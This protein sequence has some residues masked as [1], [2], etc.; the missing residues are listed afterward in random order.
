M[1]TFVKDWLFCCLAFMCNI[2]V[3]VL[4]D[5]L[6][7]KSACYPLRCFFLQIFLLCFCHNFKLRR[8][9]GRFEFTIGSSRGLRIYADR[10]R[11]NMISAIS[12]LLPAKR[13][14]NYNPLTTTLGIPIIWLVF[15]LL[16]V[17]V[18]TPMRK[19]RPLNE[20]KK[21]HRCWAKQIK[22]Q[23]M[24]RRYARAHNRIH[25]N[26]ATLQNVSLCPKI[27]TCWYSVRKY[28]LS[29]TLFTYRHARLAFPILFLFLL[30]CPFFVGCRLLYKVDICRRSK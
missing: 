3:T 18:Y 30:Q 15:T 17:R 25:R 11:A 7:V 24:H 8:I 5:T 29:L 28:S 20:S 6:L 10:E 22:I 23:S 9:R 27:K 21:L 16:L 19:K 14:I 4:C 12:F 26:S 13:S 2:V 1:A